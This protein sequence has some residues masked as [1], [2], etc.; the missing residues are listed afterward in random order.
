MI[1]LIAILALM[2]QQEGHAV[3]NSG[4]LQPVAPPPKE[5]PIAEP[6]PELPEIPAGGGI[7]IA[8]FTQPYICCADCEPTYVDACGPIDADDEIV[9]PPEIEK[10]PFGPSPAPD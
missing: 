5:M 6:V 1:A 3:S 9:A 4:V 8:D 2:V 7:V 10:S